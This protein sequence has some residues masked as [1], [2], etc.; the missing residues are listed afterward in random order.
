L[1][2]SQGD[3]AGQALTYHHLASAALV[4]GDLNGAERQSQQTLTLFRRLGHV[5][6]VLPLL[7][8]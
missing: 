5:Q 2:R 3:V 4:R 7:R 6:A 1:H 8:L